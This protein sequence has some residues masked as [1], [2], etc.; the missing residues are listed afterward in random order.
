MQPSDDRHTL[1]ILALLL[2]VSFALIT[3]E[4]RVPNSPPIAMLKA[5]AASVFGPL[6]RG[7]TALVRPI[8]G[9]RA[10]VGNSEQLS[11]EVDRLRTENGALR[12][13]LSATSVNNAEV[14]ELN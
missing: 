6:Q 5:G 7:A 12:Q 3:L 1:R 9:L 10:R 8:D 11:A 14:A 13:Q 4:A 2:G